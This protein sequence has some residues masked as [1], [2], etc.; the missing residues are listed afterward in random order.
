VQSDG[1]AG[2]SS[3]PRFDLHRSA[4]IAKIRGHSLH[5]A[6]QSLHRLLPPD[7]E[8]PLHG[9]QVA[10]AVSIRISSLELRQELARSL[11]R[12]RLQLLVG[13]QKEWTPGF[14]KLWPPGFRGE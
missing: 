11:V 10:K 13:S 12:V 7:P 6:N 2:R 9:T 4:L 3:W 1:E 14:S 8:P 5:V